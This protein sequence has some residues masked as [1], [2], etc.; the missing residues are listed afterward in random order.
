[1][2]TSS[3]LQ[4]DRLILRPLVLGDLDD[5]L[6]IW[7]NPVAMRYY[8]G[9]RSREELAGMVERSQK[10]YERD[11]TGFYALIDRA[12]AAWIGQCG[13]LWQE[14][15]SVFELEIG[16]QC[17][18][19]YWRQGYASEAALRLRDFAFTE[20]RRQHLISLI[21]PT[22]EASQGVAR[23]IGMKFWKQ[24][25]YK[26]LEVDVFRIDRAQWEKR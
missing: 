9:T 7:G 17:K 4:T 1:M 2:P 26:T 14:V 16:Y 21:R 10:S 20:L 15:D 6:G 11:R 5:M 19:R 13:L 12:S 24:S 23:K 22:N 8:P 3:P 25:V 18:P